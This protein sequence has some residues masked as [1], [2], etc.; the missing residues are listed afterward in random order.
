M[1]KKILVADDDKNLVNLITSRLE[2]SGYDVIT[3]NDG[4]KAFDAASNELPDII[5]L[6][7]MMPK[8]EGFEVCKKLKSQD[9]TKNIPVIMLTALSNESDLTEGLEKGADSFL[10]KPFIADDLLAEIEQVLGE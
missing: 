3:A 10:T 6:D 4:L 5:I 1:A 7:V 9:S 2:N 8:M